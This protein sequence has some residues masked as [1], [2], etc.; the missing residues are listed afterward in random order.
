MADHWIEFARRS[1]ILLGILLVANAAAA[2]PPDTAS[3]QTQVVSEGGR[4]LLE[5]HT[6]PTPIVLNE[7]FELLVTVR[8]RLKQSPAKN[9][10]LEVDAGMLAHNHGMFTSPEV[11]PTG[12]GE[13]R[14]KGMLFHMFGEWNLTFVLRR[15]LMKD[16]VITDIQVD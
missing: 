7:P 14:I 16:K 2:P 10:S 12:A 11:I 4:Y 1:R 5:Y 3:D 9:V 8:E 6:H 15:G 13:F